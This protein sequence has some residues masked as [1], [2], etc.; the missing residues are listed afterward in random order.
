MRVL[1][2]LAAQDDGGEGD[3]QRRGHQQQQPEHGED[4][5]HLQPV[6]YSTVQCSTV[7]YSTVP[8]AGAAPRT[9]GSGPAC[10]DTSRSRSGAAGSRPAE[11]RRY[12][13]DI[14][15]V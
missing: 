11:K 12:R 8:G 14:D 2:A 7:Q 13:V 1:P 5:E 10:R 15:T 4:G 9:R 6:Q 3:E